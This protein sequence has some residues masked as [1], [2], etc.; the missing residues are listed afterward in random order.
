VVAL[1]GEIYNVNDITISATVDA[2]TQAQI[3][4]FKSVT[5][6][7][8]YHTPINRTLKLNFIKI[9]ALK[10]SG[11]GGSPV[12]NVIGYSYSRVT[13]GR[14]AIFDTEIDTSV[15][16]NLILPLPDPIVFTGREVIYFEAS[17]DVNNTKLSVRFSG[18]EVDS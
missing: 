2:T 3:P 7:C 17:T 11:G 14:Y 9:S 4:A 18:D 6:Q 1:G 12:V 15:E 13:G 5:Q 16:N 8:I 10:V